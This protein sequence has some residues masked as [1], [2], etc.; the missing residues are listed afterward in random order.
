MN[1]PV[2]GAVAEEF[3]KTGTYRSIRCP[4]CGDYGVSDTV[5]DA[6]M[7]EK[8]EPEQRRNVL[9]K[10]KSSAQSGKRPMIM[11]YSL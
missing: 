7:L 3:P 4:S 10:A 11:S 8:L 1:C 6:G 9:A 2:C 5:Y